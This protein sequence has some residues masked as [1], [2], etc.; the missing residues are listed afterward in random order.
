MR[1]SRRWA[2]LCLGVTA[3]ASALSCGGRASPAAIR[4]ITD[5]T[6]SNVAPIFAAFTKATGARVDVVYLDKGLISR[7]ESRPT[8]A[9]VV[10]TRDA[11]LLEIA[12]ARGLLQPFASKRIEEAVP[13]E[14]RDPQGTYFSDAYRARVI[15]YS[16]DR[17]RPDELSTYEDLGADRWKGRV[18]IRSG[19][20]DY[21]LS[22]FGQLLVKNGPERTRAFLERLKANLATAP[23]G[24]DRDQ[25]RAIFEGRCDV[26][27][28]NSY[29]MGIM[30]ASP[31]QRAWGLATRVFFPDQQG[32]GAFVLRSGLALTKATGN[33]EAA[34]ELLEYVVQGNTQDYMAKLT[35][36]YPVHGRGPLPEV[37]RALGAGQAGVSNGVFKICKV[38]LDAVAAQ[39]DAVI[40][41][42]DE[43]TFDQRP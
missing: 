8:E 12:R 23:S 27:L 13:A 21:N 39:R 40:R 26:A 15:Y 28:A 36:A 4:V 38:P 34:R 2:A 20:H 17:V 33:V 19:Y 18:C 32:C 9:D 3:A 11:D 35:Y 43:I 37:N 42:L 31:D 22:L 41:M 30:L 5:R 7:L 14:Y 1:I 16:K 6:E 29:Y 10:V 24:N 25:A